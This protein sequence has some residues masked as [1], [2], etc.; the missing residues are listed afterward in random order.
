MAVF[1]CKLICK[2]PKDMDDVEIKR[3]LELPDQMHQLVRESEAEGFKFLR[4]LKLEFEN[5]VNLFDKEGEALFAVFKDRCLL[6]VGGVNQNAPGDKD[7]GRLR[8]FYVRRSCR[9]NSV[10]TRLLETIE[11][12]AFQHFSQIKIYTDTDKASKFYAKNGYRKIRMEDA[13][14]IK[15]VKK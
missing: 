1:G 7:V 5:G 14:F 6:A 4:R 8:R 3:I 13:N 9:G 15:F 12:F 10:G 2:Q 11:K